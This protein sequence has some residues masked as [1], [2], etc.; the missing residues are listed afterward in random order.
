MFLYFTR[1]T[2]L[3]NLHFSLIIEILFFSLSKITHSFD[4]T[5]YDIQRKGRRRQDDD[6]GAAR[7]L[8]GLCQGEAGLRPGF[9]LPLVPLHGAPA[10]GALHPEGPALSP[11]RLAAERAV[12]RGALRHP[13]H[14]PGSRRDIPGA[15][16]LW[17]PARH[18]LRRIRLRLLRLPR[19]LHQGRGRQLHR[20][21]RLPR[22]R[23]DP[24]GHRHAVAPE[25]P[26]RR[27]RHPGRGHPPGALLEQGLRLGGHPSGREGSP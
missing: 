27:G 22:F 21:Q 23:R 4:G 3:L 5:C 17:L 6:H 12:S 18:P 8:P 11:L 26:R 25:R 7:L 9:R 15:G 14:P 24:H 10:L 13:Q 19:A 2:L 20:G 1:K 16:G